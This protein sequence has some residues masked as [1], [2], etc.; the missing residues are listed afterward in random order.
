MALKKRSGDQASY[1]G[2]D[3]RDFLLSGLKNGSL[4]QFLLSYRIA[5]LRHVAL[6]VVASLGQ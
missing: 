2:M 5:L 3:H 6:S 4:E 1:L